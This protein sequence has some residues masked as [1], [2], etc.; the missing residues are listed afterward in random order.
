MTSR[1]AVPRRSVRLTSLNAPP[2]RRRGER[3]AVH[4]QDAEALVVRNIAPAD[5]YIT[6][7]Q[8]H[9]HH[10]QLPA[11]ALDDRSDPSPGARRCAA[12]KSSLTVTSVSAKAPAAGRGEARDV[13]SGSPRSGSETMRRSPGRRSPRSRCSR[14]RPRAS[15]RGRRRA[16]P[17]CV[18]RLL[19]RA[20]EAREHVGEALVGVVHEPRLRERLVVTRAM[21]KVAMPRAALARSPPPCRAVPEVA[22]ELAVE[23]AHYQES[24]AGGRRSRLRSLPRCGRRHAHH[25]SAMPAITTLW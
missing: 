15:R 4:P 2:S 13:E 7:R 25:P 8:R 18:P 22:P 16:A 23:D 24:S 10:G 19:R 5:A 1:G 3:A 21:T 6:R 20:H 9:A 11:L 14:A 17:R 12:A